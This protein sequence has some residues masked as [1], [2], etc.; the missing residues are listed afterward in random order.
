MGIKKKEGG[1]EW[2]LR[3]VNG[4]KKFN[5]SLRVCCCWLLLCLRYVCAFV[6]NRRKK[7]L[8]SAPRYPSQRAPTYNPPP[9]PRA[10]SSRPSERRS[11]NS[12]CKRREG[13]DEV[14][15][16]EKS[17]GPLAIPLSVCSSQVRHHE[18]PGEQLEQRRGGSTGDSVQ[19]EDKIRSSWPLAPGG[20]SNKKTTM[21]QCCLDEQCPGAVQKSTL[22]I[23]VLFFLFFWRGTGAGGG[24]TQG[25]F[26]SNTSH[27]LWVGLRIGRW[28]EIPSLPFPS[29]SP[30]RS[31]YRVVSGWERESKL[32]S[33][34]DLD[35]P[36]VGSRHAGRDR[37]LTGVRLCGF[38][39]AHCWMLNSMG[40]LSFFFFSFPRGLLH[41]NRIFV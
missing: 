21:A 27:A 25:L 36:P 29:P 18:G 12:A 11:L 6:R 23:G 15:T 39:I 2:I 33:L 16:G 28:K 17:N 5:H 8:T 35:K 30:S 20:L 24:V 38:Q 1:G 40:V 13:G 3:L 9:P 22:G 7:K 10:Q 32:D 19:P 26:F 34:L 31:R 37:R 41:E 4:K 14:A